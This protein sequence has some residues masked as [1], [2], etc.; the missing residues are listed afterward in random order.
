MDELQDLVRQMRNVTESWHE[1]GT[2]GVS[3]E[4]LAVTVTW[5][6]DTWRSIDNR[7]DWPWG[8]EIQK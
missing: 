5:M 2:D 6:T 1:C 8:K 3:R 4:D 7:T